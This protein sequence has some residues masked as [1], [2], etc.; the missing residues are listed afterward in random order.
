MILDLGLI[1][2]IWTFKQTFDLMFKI[3]ED[4]SRDFRASTL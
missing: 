1:G 4:H 3:G 2:P